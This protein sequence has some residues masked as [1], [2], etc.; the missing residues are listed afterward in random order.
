MMQISIL[1]SWHF[2]VA[3]A[4]MEAVT[5][6]L[7]KLGFSYFGNWNGI[8]IGIIGASSLY[9]FL[10][11]YILPIQ[12][13]IGLLKKVQYFY[14]FCFWGALLLA[15]LFQ[16]QRVILF[17]FG[18]QHNFFFLFALGGTSAFFAT[19]VSLLLYQIIPFQYLKASI[20][21]DEQTYRISHFS[22]WPIACSVALYEAL[23]IPIFVLKTSVWSAAFYGGVGG[24]VASLIIVV[25]MRLCRIKIWITLYP[26]P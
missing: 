24:F 26:T 2:I 17:F 10:T 3:I 23:A 5:V 16:I 1:P 25:L 6:P 4:I 20:Q 12:T 9:A 22:I 21:I 11:Y 14:I 18:Y 15:L 7:V 8:L 13:Q 19:L